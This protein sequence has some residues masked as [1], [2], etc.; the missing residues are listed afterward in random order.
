[1]S[2]SKPQFSLPVLLH[3]S[4]LDAPIVAGLWSWF[5][6]VAAHHALPI[7]APL[8][9]ALGVWVLYI[10]DRL[11]DA[12]VLH[13]RTGRQ[14]SLSSQ[15]EARH[16]FHARHGRAFLLCLVAASALLLWLVPTHVPTDVRRAYIPLAALL[17]FYFFQVHGPRR[18]YTFPKELAVGILFGAATVVPIWARAPDL[19]LYLGPA[20]ALFAAVCWLN[21]MAIDFWETDSTHAK[22]PN[23]LVLL[24]SIITLVSLITMSVGLAPSLRPVIVTA[25]ACM[26]STILLLLLHYS[27]QHFTRIGLRVAADAA[28]LSPILLLPFL[29]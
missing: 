19:H 16:Y 22:S 17:P 7:T 14:A 10:A 2:P 25:T 27:R 13:L 4:S 12:R 5:F 24:A 1:M 6:A 3:L 26:I 15:L 18:F 21:C 28:L 9:L 20:A 11:L 8:I 23:K 29:H